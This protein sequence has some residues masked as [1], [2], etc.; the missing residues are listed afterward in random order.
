MRWRIWWRSHPCLLQRCETFLCPVTGSQPFFPSQRLLKPLSYTPD[1]HLP[2]FPKSSFHLWARSPHPLTHPQMLRWSLLAFF[3]Q[4]PSPFPSKCEG[5]GLS[6]GVW[7]H[8]VVRV[9][10]GFYCLCFI[11]FNV[12]FPKYKTDFG[13]LDDPFLGEHFMCTVRYPT[14]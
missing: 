8:T 13:S 5:P 4:S 10:F 6:D 9:G 3:P 7:W 2:L 14:E 11:P 1:A 12:Y